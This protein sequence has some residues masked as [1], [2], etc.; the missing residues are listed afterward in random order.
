MSKLLSIILAMGLSFLMFL[1]MTWMIKPEILMVETKPTPP[2]SIV[3]KETDDE[4]KD[5]IRVLPKFEKPDLPA[6]VSEVSESPKPNKVQPRIEHV[7]Y[8]PKNVVVS[9][10]IFGSSGNGDASAVPKVR[11]DPRY[12]RVAAQNGLEG[13]VTLTF[14]INSMGAT[15]NISIVDQKPRGVFA[16]AARKALAKWKY[17]PKMEGNVA[18]AQPGQKITLE[19]NLE[20]EML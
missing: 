1:G 20:K 8:H 6:V 9:T 15:E 2:I 5:K 13:Y 14:D 19:F 12:P 4:P 11:I 3:Y 10:G 16:K 18:V 7:A 17:K